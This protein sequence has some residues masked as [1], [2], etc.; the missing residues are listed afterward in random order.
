MSRALHGLSVQVLCL[1]STG[2]QAQGQGP[3][4]QIQQAHPASSTG[5][6]CPWLAVNR[7][8]VRLASKFAKAFSGRG[9][10]AG[11]AEAMGLGVGLWLLSHGVIRHENLAAACLR[12]R[13]SCFRSCS[14]A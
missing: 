8:K 12:A 3:S 5:T 2:V 13:Q 9:S 7:S 6:L 10:M 11:S 4:L 14:I 1:Q